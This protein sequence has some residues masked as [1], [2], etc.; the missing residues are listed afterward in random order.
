M[1][2][3]SDEVMLHGLF[4]SLRQAI[5]IGVPHRGMRARPKRDMSGQVKLKGSVKNT[6]RGSFIEDRRRFASVDAAVTT[7]NYRSAKP[8]APS[9]PLIPLSTHPEEETV[10]KVVED[11][12][13][14]AQK[15]TLAAEHHALAVYK[16]IR[17]RGQMQMKAAAKVY[18]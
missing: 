14:P 16:L 15:L 10:E 7:T 8:V 13:K 17:R 1:E 18:V 12:S 9:V 3:L 4:F 2:S 6:R 11:T 5:S